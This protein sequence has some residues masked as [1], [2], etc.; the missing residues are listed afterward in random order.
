[1]HQKKMIQMWVDL[2]EDLTAGTAMNAL[3]DNIQEIY[4]DVDTESK[5]L[6]T[7]YRNKITSA[8]SSLKVYYKGASKVRQKHLTLFIFITKH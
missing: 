3:P 6:A 7:R 4:F 5:V 8:S 1:L 2:V